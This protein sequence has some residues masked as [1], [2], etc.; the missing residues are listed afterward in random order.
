MYNVT[1][2]PQDKKDSRARPPAGLP[3]TV[4]LLPAVIML[5]FALPHPKVPGGRQGVGAVPGLSGHVDPD[6]ARLEEAVEVF[7][8]EGH[9]FLFLPAGSD[10]P[11]PVVFKANVNAA[12]RLHDAAA[13]FLSE[14]EEIL[15]HQASKDPGSTA[16]IS[17]SF[18]RLLSS[19]KKL[20]A[21]AAGVLESRKKGSEGL[22][23]GSRSGL[24]ASLKPVPCRPINASGYQEGD[25]TALESQLQE[26][27]LEFRSGLMEMM[28][29]G[30]FPPDP[31][32][33]PFG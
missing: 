32:P 14:L 31:D 33:E 18:M 11:S 28:R 23:S 15:S 6:I 2:K 17:P 30:V 24:L 4:F 10:Q 21:H 1:G 12:F 16:V 25:S 9:Y 19:A 20:E 8:D 26:T 27:V 7:L 3:L 29:T 13:R 5:L 22:E